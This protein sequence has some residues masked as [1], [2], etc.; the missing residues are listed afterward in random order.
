MSRRI[1]VLASGEMLRIHPVTHW[2][3]RFEEFTERSATEIALPAVGYLGP[4]FESVVHPVPK[5]LSRQ[6]LLPE[7][8]A[9]AR[10][11]MGEDA[12]VWA[13]IIMELGFLGN[14]S[15][16]L[17]DQ[18]GDPLSQA[19]LSHPVVQGILQTFISELSA[20][21]VDG[22]ILDVTDAYPNSTGSKKE[23]IGFLLHCFC[24]YCTNGMKLRGFRGAQS[25]FARE[26]SPAR[27]VLRVDEEGVAHIDPPHEWLVSRQSEE[28]VNIALAR[29]FVDGDSETLLADASR[30][31]A[32]MRARVEVTAEAI[33]TVL[34][35][36]SA[37]GIR[38]AVVLGDYKADL[39][40]MVTLPALSETRSADE[41]WL[42][43]APDKATL[44]GEWRAVQFLG[45]RATYYTN[46][47][48]E[49]VENADVWSVRAGPES[50]L[51]TLL[52]ASKGLMSNHF[53]A[54]GAYTAEKL[55]Q[56]E[57]FAGVPLNQADHL[58]IVEQLASAATGDVFPPALLQRF[59]ITTADQPS[60]T[61]T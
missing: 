37:A 35:A 4:L 13:T 10:E 59:R 49:A 21:G 29:R 18:Y 44:P 33:R 40:Q 51:Q 19:C 11:T 54:G 6:N 38:S 53:S 16:F 50:F 60:Q 7:W 9:A 2:L 23:R 17:V 61:A 14:E 46:T 26:P 34:T 1:C 20:L 47:F 43:S 42:P 5:N 15:V 8:I 28:L 32:Y 36:A 41:Y 55:S 57:G 24:E 31:L 52:R 27:F 30:L 3:K 56:F 39:S 48:F 22:V 12:T 45:G 25:T 58:E